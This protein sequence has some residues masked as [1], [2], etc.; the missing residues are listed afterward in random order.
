MTSSEPLLPINPS[1]KANSNSSSSRRFSST[2]DL[3][4]AHPNLNF[5][6]TSTPEEELS[7]LDE[8]MEPP[9]FELSDNDRMISIK[10]GSSLHGGNSGKRKLFGRGKRRWWNIQDAPPSKQGKW[11]ILFEAVRLD[12][13]KRVL[14]TLLHLGTTATEE[15]SLPMM[16]RPDS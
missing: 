7:D 5:L 11:S 3:S 16:K 12:L 8:L 9:E 6:Q 15:D 10:E 1:L 13:F 4:P 2:M 14:T